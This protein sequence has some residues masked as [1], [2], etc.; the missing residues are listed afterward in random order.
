MKFAFIREH[1]GSFP[2]RLLC[3]V[4]DVSPSGF[5]AWLSRKPSRRAVENEALA[6]EIR[7]IHAGSHGRYGSP[8]VHAEL[9]RR[10][11]HIGIRRVERVM[12]QHGICGIVTPRRRPRTTDSRHGLPVAPNR[13]GR[14]FSAERPNQVWA[15][16]LTYIRTAEGWLYLAAI[17]DLCTRKIVGWAMRDTLHAE[18]V[19]A[20]LA[21]AVQRQRPAPGLMHHSDRGVQYASEIFQADLAAAGIVCSMSRRGDALDNAPAESFFHTLKTELVHHRT[22]A[23]RDEARRDLFAFIE[24]FYNPRRLHSA[25][26][27]KSPAEME[28]LSA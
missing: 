9:R 7:A 1:A 27:Y 12:R 16:D 26:G 14:N 8:R 4:L 13:L 5:Y 2:V 11:R 10:G 21:M 23:S 18:I 24:G 15:A 19:R 17:I 20:A 3:E 22:Y 28:Q 6:A 25:L